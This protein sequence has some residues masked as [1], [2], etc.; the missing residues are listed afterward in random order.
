MPAANDPNELVQIRELSAPRN[1]VFEAWSS[2]AHLEKWFAPDGFTCTY[3][4]DFRT[5]GA[6]T[7]T[8]RGMGMEHTVRGTYHEVSPPSRIVQEMIFED[9]PDQKVILVALFEAI[10]G[11][12]TR[13]T[14]R[15]TF[16]PPYTLTDE[17]RAL[18]GPRVK[19]APIGWGQTLQH[20]KD[21]VEKR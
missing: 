5:G 10:A 2:S 14:I 15:Q 9:L 20:L 13:L 7:L 21:Y 17:Q 18:L 19:G 8:M 3:A 11:D 16:P 12:K 4:V 1:L 6:F